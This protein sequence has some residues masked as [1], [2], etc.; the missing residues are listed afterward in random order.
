ME[1]PVTTETDPQRLA[2]EE[3]RR[4]LERRKQLIRCV[5]DSWILSEITSI[6]ARCV[7]LRETLRDERD[8]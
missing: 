2:R 1:A 6:E 8:A 5:D 4:L 7:V 3:L